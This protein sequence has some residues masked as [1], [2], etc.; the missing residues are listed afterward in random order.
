MRRFI[1]TLNDGSF[2][3]I[4]ATKMKLV[5]D[6]VQVY[7]YDDLIALVDISAV[8]TAHMSERGDSRG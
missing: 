6:M 2:I 4:P 3:N 5:E 7:E 1:A 8:V